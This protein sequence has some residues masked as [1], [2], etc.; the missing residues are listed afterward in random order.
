M[1]EYRKCTMSILRWLSTFFRSSENIYAAIFDILWVL[2][3]LTAARIFVLT[4]QGN[5]RVIMMSN[6]KLSV[7]GGGNFDTST[8]TQIFCAKK[9]FYWL[10]D[11]P[12]TSNVALYQLLSYTCFS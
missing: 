5:T 9:Y 3:S 6:W 7:V 1:R 10:T 12:N 11:G 8:F 2:P 4:K